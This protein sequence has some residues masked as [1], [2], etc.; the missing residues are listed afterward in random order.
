MKAK[1]KNVWLPETALPPT[2]EY[3]NGKPRAALFVPLSMEHYRES[4]EKGREIVR[5]NRGATKQW[6]EEEVRKAMKMRDGGMKWV[7]IGKEFG[8]TDGAVRRLVE[9]EK[10]KQ[11]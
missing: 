5:R 3:H 4:N 11:Q 9:R 1:V 2:K 8:V 7:A 6:T 10:K